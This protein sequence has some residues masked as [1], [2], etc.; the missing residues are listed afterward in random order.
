MD[1]AS[2]V[3]YSSKFKNDIK[4][5]FIIEAMV[6]LVVPCYTF[7]QSLLIYLFLFI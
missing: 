5:V 2:N 1:R 6:G 3:T 7:M 4:I